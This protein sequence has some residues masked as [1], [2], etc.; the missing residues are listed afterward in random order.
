M[1]GNLTKFEVAQF[2]EAFALFDTNKDGTLEPDEL[3][4][5]M[6][7]LGQECTD[8]EIKDIIDVADELGT[9]RIDFPSFL[10]QFQHADN[11]NPLEMLDE[12]FLLVGKGQD[13]TEAAVKTFLSSVGQTIID[14]EAQE[15]IK[16]LD[17]DGDGKV[18]VDDFKD[19]W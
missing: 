11:E 14:V 19:I 8:E 18:N 16:V 13:I 4:F 12:A 3:K 2:K 17:K 10:K 15:I 9:G 1:A 7:A 6:S 5:V